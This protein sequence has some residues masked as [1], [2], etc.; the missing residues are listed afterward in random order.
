[1]IDKQSMQSVLDSPAPGDPGWNMRFI[2]DVSIPDAPDY[3]VVQGAHVERIYIVVADR[4]YDHFGIT[5]ESG[6]E[7]DLE[8]D[9]IVR[10]AQMSCRGGRLW[11]QWWCR[12]TP[13]A[14][15]PE[16]SVL[17]MLY[18]YKT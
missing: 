18:P 5:L 4:Y 11:G 3:S 1:M 8:P 16:P 6:E 17:T 13:R 12:K 15:D 7:V 9:T 10:P 2:V 14:L